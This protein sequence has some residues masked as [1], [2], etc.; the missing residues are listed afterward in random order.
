VLFSKDWKTFCPRMNVLAQRRGS[1]RA[2][3]GLIRAALVLATVVS[4]S[5]AEVT[6]LGTLGGR[7]SRAYAINAGGDVVGESETRGGAVQA[8]LWRPGSGMTNLGTLGGPTSCAYDINNR[9]EVVGES[10]TTAGVREAFLWTPTGGMVRLAGSGPPRPSYAYAIN[11]AGTVA[12]GIDTADGMQAV[13]WSNGVAAPLAIDLD[14]GS[15][16]YDINALG[17]TAGQ[18]DRTEP[19]NRVS[20]A[21]IHRH[22]E[23]ANS[24]L[25]RPAGL[26]S[27]AK[28][29]N[30]LHQ[31]TGYFETTNGTTHA[32]VFDGVRGLQ[33]IDT[34][35]NAY[36]SASGINNRGHVVGAF[37]REGTDDDRAFFYDGKALQ[38]LNEMA[39]SRDWLF[40]E[41]CDLNDRGEIVGYGWHG[42]AERAFLLRL[43]P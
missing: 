10:V 14:A 9:G 30:D 33:D 34:G 27:S 38:D 8:F 3:Q 32:F 21:F 19:G 15:V 17:Y 25:P 23:P 16:A 24:L 40:V 35:N 43:Q 4:T 13:I 2:G 18:V 37:F 20:A 42:D 26:S 1:P 11:D 29:L 41:A 39:K 5:A 12:G 7:S 36:S 6:D 31:A 28:A 22:A